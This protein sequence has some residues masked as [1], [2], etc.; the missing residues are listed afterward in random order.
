MPNGQ[1]I[2][3]WPFCSNYIDIV[4]NKNLSNDMNVNFVSDRFEVSKNAI[5]LSLGFL[6]APNGVYFN[7]G[8]FT[9]MAWIK[10]TSF[11][12]YSRILDFGNGDSGQE[13]DNII[14]AYNGPTPGEPYAEICR[15]SSRVLVLETDRSLELGKWQHIAFV[16]NS[17]NLTMQLYVDAL[18]WD[19]A[20]STCQFLFFFNFSDLNLFFNN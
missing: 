19:S 16:Y 1:L 8:D 10:P 6:Q 14:C 15:D 2:D 17:S 9:V 3:Y 12:A 11:S 18:W 13:Y 5:D 4:T 7:G 20:N